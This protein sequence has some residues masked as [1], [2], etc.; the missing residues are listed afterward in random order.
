MIKK[1]AKWKG[2]IAKG[3]YPI[4]ILCGKEITKVS[5]LSSE[6]LIPLSRSGKTDEDNVCCSHKTCNT[7]KG[8]MTLEEWYA[9][10]INGKQR[11]KE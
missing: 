1:I 6:H 8:N 9:Y 3:I 10:L 2:K 11:Q 4:C 5:E 7:R